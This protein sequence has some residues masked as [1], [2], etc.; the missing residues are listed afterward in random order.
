MKKTRS[1]QRNKITPVNKFK[2]TEVHE[3]PGKELKITIINVL[4]E[5]KTM[6]GKKMTVSIAD[7]INQKKV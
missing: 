2:V 4:N 7:L 3:L 5:L 1:N 6:N